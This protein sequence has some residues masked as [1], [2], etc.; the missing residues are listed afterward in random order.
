M[1]NRQYCTGDYFLLKKH[2]ME[3]CQNRNGCRLYNDYKSALA[4][5]GELPIRDR[6]ITFAGLKWFRECKLWKGH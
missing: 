2:K 5:M 3:A 6:M 1:E 4:G